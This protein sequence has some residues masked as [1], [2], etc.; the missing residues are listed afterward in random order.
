MFSTPVAFEPPAFRNAATY[1]NCKTNSLN[2]DDGPMYSPNLIRYPWKRPQTVPPLK[3][4]RRKCG[5]SSLYLS[6][7]LI[8]LLKFCT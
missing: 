6:S 5:Q 1:L 7:E 4:R 2:G 3:I 8:M